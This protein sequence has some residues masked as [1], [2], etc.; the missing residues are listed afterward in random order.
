MKNM[1]V[2]DSGL[3][4]SEANDGFY[5]G[6]FD[7]EWVSVPEH[8]VRSLF[9]LKIPIHGVAVAKRWVSGD[10]TQWIES[11]RNESYI[12]VNVCGYEHEITGKEMQDLRK[13]LLG[14]YSYNS[15]FDPPPVVEA[16]VEVEKYS[17]TDD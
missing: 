5:F 7:N 1:S 13:I 12:T 17:D 9:D 10:K 8:A 14:S 11:C 6:S 4:I 16:A 3:K 2:F 15:A